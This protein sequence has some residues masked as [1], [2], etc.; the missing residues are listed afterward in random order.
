MKY[1]RIKRTLPHIHIEAVQLLDILERIAGDQHEVIAMTLEN[2]Y[3]NIDEMRNGLKDFVK[4]FARRPIIRIGPVT[5]NVGYNSK[6]PELS[7]NQEQLEK[8]RLE[9]GA[10]FE[11][12]LLLLD[13]L[14]A[15]LILHK[16]RFTSL[17]CL[18]SNFVNSIAGRS[19]VS[20]HVSSSS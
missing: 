5:F 17:N 14:E 12:A 20:R 1:L 15:E 6:C 7:I 18:L 2:K 19:A 9:P 13:S 16:S 8:L 10:V 11:Q 3:E 4:D